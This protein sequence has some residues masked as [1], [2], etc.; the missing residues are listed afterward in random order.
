MRR[1][2]K[3][4]S[5]LGPEECTRKV[6]SG[7]EGA[8]A[9]ARRGEWAGRRVWGGGRGGAPSGG[10]GCLRRRGGRGGNK[11]HLGLL[12]LALWHLRHVSSSVPV[13]HGRPTNSVSTG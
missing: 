9:S 3:P 2:R 12:R 1:A 10:V 4:S 7:E 11:L 5:P 6:V 13:V 8:E